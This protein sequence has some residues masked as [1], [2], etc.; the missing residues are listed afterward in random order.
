MRELPD[1]GQTDSI[2][3]L[4]HQRAAATKHEPT[5]GRGANDGILHLA[6]IDWIAHAP[7]CW[8]SIHLF[9]WTAAMAGR[10]T[11]LPFPACHV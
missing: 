6:A 3:S 7:V 11:F 1:S 4:R 9:P 5:E 10:G 8:Q 2:T